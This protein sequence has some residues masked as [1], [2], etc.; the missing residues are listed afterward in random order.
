MISVPNPLRQ[1]NGSKWIGLLALLLLGLSSCDLFKKIPEKDPI[2]DKDEDLGE[3]TGPKQRDPN[4]GEYQTVVVL[5]ETM[6]T[7]VWKF[8][9]K[10]KFPPIQSPDGSIASDPNTI[11]GVDPGTDPNLNLKESYQI[12]Y[13]L[14]FFISKLDTST[15]ASDIYP[16]AEW[17]VHYYAGVQLALT[18]LE[19]EGARLNLRVFDTEGDNTVL[20]RQLR[21][22]RT[23]RQ[24]DLLMGPYKS[25]NARLLAQYARS[26][27]IPMVSPY[28]ANSNVTSQNPFYV[29]L[30]PSLESHCVAIT[31][32]VAERYEDEQV[33]LVVRNRPDELRLM[34][35]FQNTLRRIRGTDTVR[36]QE[37]II[38]DET[39]DLR[40]VD[41]L[42]YILADRPTVFIIPSYNDESFVYS[43][44]RKLKIATLNFS[45]AVVYGFPQWME[46]DRIDFDLY[47][48][49]EVHVSSAF[50]VDEYAPEIQE[51]K[52]RFFD[53]YGTPP[54]EEAYIGYEST[55]YFGR[56]VAKYGKQFM[57]FLPAEDRKTLYTNYRFREIYNEPPGPVG[58]TRRQAQVERYEN[59]FVQILKF[60]DY[61]FQPAE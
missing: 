37:F 32:H 59:T 38:R 7:L 10:D 4:T 55:L 26:E 56:L 24:S 23:I 2:K 41:V 17:G 48:D 14:P 49:L 43:M 60:Q 21:S 40:N 61:Y 52:R 35:L 6:D 53:E 31:E 54:H 20:E 51:F 19:K 36:F 13:F 34:E 33:V 58:D 57:R 30:N 45:E 39:A 15:F 5:T 3:I 25:L 1:L 18:Q 47:E 42:P 16:P 8:R 28:S 46:F 27:N 11:P 29:Q 9:P 44:L 22:D 12:S 50:Y